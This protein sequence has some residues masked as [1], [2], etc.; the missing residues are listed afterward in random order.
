MDKFCDAGDERAHIEDDL[1][2]GELNVNILPQLRQRCHCDGIGFGTIIDIRPVEEAIRTPE[3]TKIRVCFDAGVTRWVS[4]KN[5]E[6]IDPPLTYEQM[7][8]I[9][10]ANGLRL[11]QFRSRERDCDAFDIVAVDSEGV[12]KGHLGLMDVESFIYQR[13]LT[14]HADTSSEDRLEYQAQAHLE[15]VARHR[16]DPMF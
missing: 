9:L 12:I 8:A 7:K 11:V 2:A 15:A 1:R 10:Q 5:V 6:L 4:L 13:G 14:L 16:D 3:N